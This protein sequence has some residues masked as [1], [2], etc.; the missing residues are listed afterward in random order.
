MYEEINNIN[1]PVSFKEIEL[2]FKNLPTKK[3]PDPYGFTDEF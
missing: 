1:C 2:V 3:I